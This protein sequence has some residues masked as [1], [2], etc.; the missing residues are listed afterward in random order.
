VPAIDL[1]EQLDRCL[2]IL[3]RDV[4]HLMKESVDKKL[5]PGSARDLATYLKLL[6]ELD[7]RQKT[8]IE[9]MPVEELEKLV[10]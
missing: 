2:E 5:S 1:D 7:R 4:N 9:D 6:A 8:S 3:R 10:K